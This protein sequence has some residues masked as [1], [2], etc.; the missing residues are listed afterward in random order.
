M[1]K[2]GI[3]MDVFVTAGIHCLSKLRETS[4]LSSSVILSKQIRKEQASHEDN[5]TNNTYKKQDGLSLL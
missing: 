2:A 5:L 4:G 1:G 3:Y